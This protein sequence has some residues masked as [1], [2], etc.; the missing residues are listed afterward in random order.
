MHLNRSADDHDFTAAVHRRHYPLAVI[1]PLLAA[2]PVVLLV[3]LL[4]QWLGIE[5]LSGA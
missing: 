4:R 2:V 5:L 3:I 1:L